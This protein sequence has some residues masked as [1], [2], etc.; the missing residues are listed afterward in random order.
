MNNLK[1]LRTKYNL[2]LQKLADAC[3]VTKPHIHQLEKGKC[4]PNLSTA[5]RISKVLDCNVYDIWPDTTKIIEKT[6]TF[7]CVVD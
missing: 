2:S 3:G 7:R 5:Y 4:G 1:S 6:V